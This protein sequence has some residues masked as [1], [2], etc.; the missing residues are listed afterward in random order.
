MSKQRRAL[1]P[2]VAKALMVLRGLVSFRVLMAL[3]TSASVTAAVSGPMAYQASQARELLVAEGEPLPSGEIRV[4]AR[5]TTT[6]PKPISQPDATTSTTSTT[7]TPTAPTEAPTSTVAPATPTVPRPVPTLQPGTSKPTT[8]VPSEFGL[9]G[10]A[11]PKRGRPVP[12]EYAEGHG[13]IYLYFELPGTKSVR[14]WLD[15]PTKT[16]AP[17]HVAASAPFDFGTGPLDLAALTPGQHSLTAEVTTTS[18]QVYTV[19]APFTSY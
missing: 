10:S 2:L 3:T 16:G 18:G 14:F 11:L 6:A 8:T 17:T 4:G 19:T 13:P 12:L 9:Y 5:P 7:T 1:P 15:N